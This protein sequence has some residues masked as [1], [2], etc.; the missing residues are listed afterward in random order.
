MLFLWPE[1]Y[2]LV[3]SDTQSE[4]DNQDRLPSSSNFEQGVASDNHGVLNSV[5]SGYVL[6][7]E[8]IEEIFITGLI[9]YWTLETQHFADREVSGAS[10]SR[11][12][13]FVVADLGPSALR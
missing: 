6:S 2:P 12:T 4:T 9:S 1:L 5:L 3:Q 11:Q 8:D 10:M 7:Q 13:H